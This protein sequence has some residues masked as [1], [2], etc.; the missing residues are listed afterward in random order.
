MRKKRNTSGVKAC[1]EWLIANL[2]SGNYVVADDNGRLL[3]LEETP[4][5]MTDAQIGKMFD[6]ATQSVRRLRKEFNIPITAERAEKILLCNTCLK[7]ASKSKKKKATK[8]ISWYTV[9]TLVADI[10][11]VILLAAYFISS[12]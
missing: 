9:A 3:P 7:L 5:M 4:A 10:I 11:L 8:K 6:I 12:K 1:R 2:A